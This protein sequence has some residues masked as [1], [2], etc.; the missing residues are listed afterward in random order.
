MLFF[1]PP[2]PARGPS[3]L[4]SSV[5]TDFL[6]DVGCFRLRRRRGLP[7]PP[8]PTVIPFADMKMPVPSSPGGPQ[9]YSL[10]SRS[11]TAVCLPRPETERLFDSFPPR[12]LV[13]RELCAALCSAKL[14]S[15]GPSL[16]SR[17]GR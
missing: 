5:L 6:L 12:R 8:R 9:R 13:D 10:P 2:P 17:E 14:G 11:L 4:A 16:F 7:F 3:R 15:R 1:P